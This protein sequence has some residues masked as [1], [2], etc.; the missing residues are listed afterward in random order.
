MSD[1]AIYIRKGTTI[2]AKKGKEVAKRGKGDLIGEMTLLLGD[3]P[4]VTIKAETAVDVYIVAH[5]ELTEFLITDPMA[6]GRV[7]RMMASTLS[8]TALH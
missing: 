8:V 5:S 2:V 4:G 1:S 7:F 6:C 3:L